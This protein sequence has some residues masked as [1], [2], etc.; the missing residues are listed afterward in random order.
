ML[1]RL[2]HI[3]AS[4]E[5]ATFA[6]QVS[7]DLGSLFVN[8]NISAIMETQLTANQPLSQVN[9]MQWNSTSN[10]SGPSVAFDPHPVNSIADSLLITMHPLQIRTFIITL[11]RI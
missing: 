2:S 11:I 1:L 3:F 9:R 7:V 4:S 5:D 10:M 6:Q 8:Y